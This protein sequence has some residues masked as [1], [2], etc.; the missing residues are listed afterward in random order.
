M[1][2]KLKALLLTVLLLMFAGCYAMRPE[3]YTARSDYYTSQSTAYVAYANSQRQ[4]IATV[5]VPGSNSEVQIYSQIP[6][7]VPVLQQE[8]NGWVDFWK[9]TVNSTPLS[10]VAGGWSAM[11]LLKYSS[12]D[13]NIQ[14]DGN[15]ASP[16]SNSYNTRTTD[17]A[18]SS[19]DST[20]DQHADSSDNSN[21]DNSDSRSNYENDSRSD[22]DNQTATPT[23]VD[24][25][26]VN[27]VVVNPPDPI[28]VDPVVIQQTIP[29]E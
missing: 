16:I 18:T 2:M 12:G 3:M 15:T 14:G 4:P 26:V 27:P 10:I 6:A 17:V 21:V 29:S 9:A 25:L 1:K 8:R 7:V 28:I 23:V 13:V 22:Y 24:P 5:G 20:L 11:K 19:D